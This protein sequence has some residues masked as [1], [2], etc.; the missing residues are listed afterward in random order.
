M[1]YKKIL[2]RME[3]QRMPRRRFL[4][5]LI[6]LLALLMSSG[7][8]AAGENAGKPNEDSAFG[9]NLGGVTYWST[10]I[11]FVD[12]FKHSQTW[13]SQAP[14][15]KYAQGGELALSKDG[16]V[17][18]L[19]D[20]GQSADSI[21]LSSINGRYPGGVYTCL[22]DGRGQLKFA[23]GTSVADTSGLFCPA[24]RIHTANSPSIPT[25]SNDGKNSRS[26]ASWT[27]RRPTIP[28]KPISPTALLLQC[29][30]RED[31]EESPWST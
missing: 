1:A 23:Y 30:L 28:A 12:L 8:G 9:I 18:A 3:M 4:T 5:P 27:F 2:F 11:V 19:A 29:R 16:W 31:V 20:N 21:I 25:F 14:G 15:K 26:S 7:T 22:Y 6:V 13:K 17:E 24:L 10:E